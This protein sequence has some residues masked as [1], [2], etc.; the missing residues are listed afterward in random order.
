VT[1]GEI[2]FMGETTWGTI[3]FGEEEAEP[4][5]GVTALESLGIAVDPINQTL[6]RLPAI[7]L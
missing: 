2:S 7:R 1:G 4:L 5:L 3:V 6:T